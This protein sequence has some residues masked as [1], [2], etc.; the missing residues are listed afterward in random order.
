MR[1]SALTCACLQW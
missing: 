1:S